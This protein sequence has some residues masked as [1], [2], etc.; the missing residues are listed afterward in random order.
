MTETALY[1]LLS[2]TQPRHG[3]AIMQHV[4]EL[5]DG[6]VSLGP[7]TL[8][9]SISKMEADKLITLVGEE[10][11]RKIY[12]I[13]PV[14]REILSVETARIHELYTNTKGVR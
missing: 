4:G 11:K 12:E 13:T 7:G 2:L 5:T 10:E 9:G 8:Y 3:Y 6:R 14:G 1:I